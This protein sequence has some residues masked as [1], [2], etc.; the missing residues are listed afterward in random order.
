MSEHL[1]HRTSFERFLGL[2]TQLRPGEGRSVALFFLYAF[3]LLVAYYILKTLREPLLLVA[4]S[5][6][7]KSYAYAVIAALLLVLIPIYG[8]V[9]RRTEKTQL[10]R[11]LTWFFVFNLVVFYGLGKAG[12]NIGFESWYFRFQTLK[13]LNLL[14]IKAFSL[15]SLSS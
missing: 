6:E 5:A 15:S 8:F 12:I 14:H 7:L 2:F 10:T 9:F 4:G 13:D 1:R 3:L 11:G